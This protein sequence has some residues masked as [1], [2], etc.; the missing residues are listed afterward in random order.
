MTTQFNPLENVFLLA[1]IRGERNYRLD[2]IGKRTLHGIFPAEAIV[3]NNDADSEMIARF[4]TKTHTPASDIERHFKRCEESG[5]GQCICFANRSP[6]H[7]NT[8]TKEIL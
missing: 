3:D 8:M 1:T 4:T 7:G 5:I 2:K 6:F